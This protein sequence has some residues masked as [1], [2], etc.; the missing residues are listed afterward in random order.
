M[1]ALR[2]LTMSSSLATW[3]PKSYLSDAAAEHILA[4]DAE[5]AAT[6]IVNYYD[7]I[8]DHFEQRDR[9]AKIE[10]EMQAQRFPKGA[11]IA[12]AHPSRLGED[13]RP[14]KILRI[15]GVAMCVPF[16]VVLAFHDWQSDLES[17]HSVVSGRIARL[18]NVMEG[19]FGHLADSEVRQ[20]TD[21]DCAEC[22]SEP[23]FAVLQAAER[24]HRD[25]RG[26]FSIQG[27]R[28]QQVYAKALQET[29]QAAALFRD[30]ID[31]ST[32]SSP[33]HGEYCTAVED[34]ESVLCLDSS[35]RSLR[36]RQGMPLDV[37]ALSK[38]YIVDLLVELLQCGDGALHMSGGAGPEE[39]KDF[40]R[41]CGLLCGALCEWG[42]DIRVFGAPA[43][44]S[45]EQPRCA[46]WVVGIVQPPKLDTLYRQW[47]RHSEDVSSSSS[48]R[49]RS[50]LYSVHLD[51]ARA[52]AVATSG[53]YH[54]ATRFGFTHIVNPLSRRLCRAQ[55]NT[56]ASVSVVSSTAMAADGLSTALFA[57]QRLSPMLA[58]VPALRA[59]GLHRFYVYVRNQSQFVHDEDDGDSPGAGDAARSEAYDARKQTAIAM[60]AVS[61]QTS[62]FLGVVDAVQRRQDAD[63]FHHVTQRYHK[64]ID[65][66]FK[67]AGDTAAEADDGGLAEPPERLLRRLC[68]KWIAG[69]DALVVFESEA[70]S[71][72]LP[73]A[74]C[75]QPPLRLSR[76]DSVVFCQ[77]PP[78]AVS[79]GATVWLSLNVMRGSSLYN[80]VLL[81]AQ[82]PTRLLP[83]HFLRRRGEP[84]AD[85]RPDASSELSPSELLYREDFTEW[86]RR[87]CAGAA[88]E[89]QRVTLVEVGS[90]G[91]RCDTL[92]ALLGF[93]LVL[94][95]RAEAVEVA[96]DHLWALLKCSPAVRRSPSYPGGAAECMWRPTEVSYNTCNAYRPSWASPVVVI[97]KHKLV[98]SI[99]FTAFGLRVVSRH[100][101]MISVHFAKSPAS[102]VF[103]DVLS[104]AGVSASLLASPDLMLVVPKVSSR[105]FPEALEPDAALSFQEEALWYLPTP[106]SGFT[107]WRQATTSAAPLCAEDVHRGAQFALRCRLVDVVGPHEEPLL[108][109]GDTRCCIH[110]AVT[111]ILQ[112]SS[113]E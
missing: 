73:S 90:G 77:P 110:A 65:P 38:G 108:Q 109:D 19:I 57:L 23:L 27:L 82:Q 58:V 80:A 26:V 83:L 53:D 84:E 25:S 93:T 63:A 12:S 8:A 95:G 81:A 17:L 66:H 9:D 50:Y 98:G 48:S 64:L 37:D 51:S 91:R 111:A 78:S 31:P 86:S 94:V 47:K 88:S 87:Y 67:Q 45:E 1:D 55:S 29:L 36:K 102:A 5:A 3:D 60:D 103:A 13:S 92:H 2:S 24:I 105:W 79:D 99:G 4:F 42:G 46:S 101:L 18:F 28:L 72:Q 22:L 35:D 15:D 43:A 49:D 69:C 96:G 30:F 44:E 74:A 113:L 32:P 39:N 33:L 106:L 14:S 11:V 112:S 56:L 52:P 75:A 107:A 34:L 76:L 54:Q 40:A 21:V 97:A 100:P 70:R 6:T 20:L 71:A 61:R 41:V 59:C 89:E 68:S 85:T 7:Y 16:H 10:S 62:Q 104:G